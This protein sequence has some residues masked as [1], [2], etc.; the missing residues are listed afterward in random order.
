MAKLCLPLG[1][2]LAVMISADADNCLG[3]DCKAFGASSMLQ[4]EARKAAIAKK[5][6]AE[7][8]RPPANSSLVAKG[9]ME[10]D[11]YYYD[12]AE[13]DRPN[14][15]GEKASLC[16][17]TVPGK[18]PCG[19]GIFVGLGGKPNSLAYDRFVSKCE[20]PSFGYGVAFCK[21]MATKAFEGRNLN[22]P[23]PFHEDEVSEFCEEVRAL[24]VAHAHHLCLHAATQPFWGASMLT[25][26]SSQ[27]VANNAYATNSEN[28][29]YN[30]CTDSVNYEPITSLEECKGMISQF[31]QG[32][33]F[34]GTAFGEWYPPGCFRYEGGKMGRMARGSQTGKVVYLGRNPAGKGSFDY[35]MV[36]KRRTPAPTPHSSATLDQAYD[37]K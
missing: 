32:G 26:R 27:L 11:N 3:G 31:I 13:G 17:H 33:H 1:F 36:C 5:H 29:P 28:P 6:Y 34:S 20:N 9:P 18:G 16:P 23:F 21:Q 37:G 14:R 7:D 30:T 2:V 4:S 35:P 15:R 22:A 24:L 25:S 10:Y 8:V 19:L 12:D